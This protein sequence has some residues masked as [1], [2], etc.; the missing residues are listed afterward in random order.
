MNT[1]SLGQKALL[2]IVIAPFL[3]L[4]GLVLLSA[5]M[6]TDDAA[7]YAHLKD[8]FDY[9]SR[10]RADNG[11]S[12]DS[13]TECTGLALG[14]PDDPS[15]VENPFIEAVRA[16][17]VRSCPSVKLFLDG[18]PTETYDYFRYWHGYATISRPLLSMSPYT[19]LRQHAVTVSL[20]LLTILLWR[21]GKDFG[22]ASAL[23]FALA[24]LVLN[25]F[26]YWIVITKAVTWF[27]MIGGALW[28]S[29][30]KS[31]AWPCLGFFALG[32]MTAYFDFLTAPMAVFSLAALVDYAY[33]ARTDGA[34]RLKRAAALLAFF[35]FGYAG[36]WALKLLIAAMFLGDAV[37]AD[38]ADAAAIRLRGDNPNIDSFVPG[39]AIAS[40]F[41]RLKIFWGAAAFLIYLV[42]PLA[43]A[44]GRRL[45]LYCWRHAKA[46]IFIAAAPLVWL[47][48]LSNHS[49]I[50]A[51]FTQM[52][53]AAAFI[54]LGLVAF[55]E[56]R[57]LGGPAVDGDRARRVAVDAAP[58]R[59]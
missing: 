10:D 38:A 56:R 32:A 30:R 37:W 29:R 49:Q 42:A 16:P 7:I 39:A 52:N 21:I 44:R 33:A 53:F 18:A 55:G 20:I 35:M 22:A 54:L 36:L 24:F 51:H 45:L 8:D 2:A 26:A 43:T 58:E 3:A 14:L 40:N 31:E 11:R 5:A 28:A 19:D 9:L 1:L 48:I 50:H 23:S 13:L 4:L 57:L 47:E 27:L 25:A 34:V 46:L 12:V 15:A 41:L 6:T 17:T 59:A